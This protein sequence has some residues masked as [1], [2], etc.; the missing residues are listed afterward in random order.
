V[1]KHLP[2]LRFSVLT[3]IAGETPKILK[4]AAFSGKVIKNLGVENS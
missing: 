3:H 1:V 4:K 2:I